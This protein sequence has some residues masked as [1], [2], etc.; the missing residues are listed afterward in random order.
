MFLILWLLLSLLIAI[1][2]ICAILGHP[3]SLIL[4]ECQQAPPMS[5]A[6]KQFPEKPYEYPL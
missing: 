1:A 3:K 5:S 2:H 6:Y 4:P